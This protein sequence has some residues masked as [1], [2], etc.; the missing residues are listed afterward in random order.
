MTTKTKTDDQ[1]NSKN[2]L[3]LRTFLLGTATRRLKACDVEHVGRIFVQS[4]TERERGEIESASQEEF[5][6]RVIVNCLVDEEGNRLFSEDDVPTVLA[7]DT[8]YTLPIFFAISEHCDPPTK[9]KTESD[10]KN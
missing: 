8:K 9:K 5:R 4:M 2:G 3:E 10:V 1:P 6:A 7:M